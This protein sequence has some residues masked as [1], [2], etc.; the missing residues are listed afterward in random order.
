MR[1]KIT[2]LC[3]SIFTALK[4]WVA[5]Y[6]RTM[7][8]KVSQVLGTTRV[9]LFIALMCSIFYAL[10][11]QVSCVW[12]EIT[13]HPWTLILYQ[14]SH[15]NFDHLF[16]N[17]LIFVLTAPRVEEK[18]GHLKFLL[19]FLL[20]GIGSAVGFS[21]IMGNADLIGASG[22]ISGV[23]AV[24]PFVQEN[25]LIS[26]LFGILLLIYFYMQF[27]MALLSLV[28]PLESVAFLGHVAGAVSGLIILNIFNRK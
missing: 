24:A 20:S 8:R 19:L 10:N 17:M 11:I 16:G 21:L 25:I 14:F 13:M 2:K 28:F 5:R 1:L 4:N 3:G 18:L 26:L 27:C 12:S 6:N 22:A 7:G 9:T 15:M 23:L